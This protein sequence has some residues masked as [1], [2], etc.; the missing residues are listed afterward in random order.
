MKLVNIKEITVIIKN[1]EML[2]DFLPEVSVK[3]AEG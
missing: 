3:I 1:N 2:N